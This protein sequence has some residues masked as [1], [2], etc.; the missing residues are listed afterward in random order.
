MALKIAVIGAGGVGG[1]FGGRLAAAG[2]DVG[3]VARGTHLAALKQDGLTVTSV[4]GDFTIA[5]VQAT[6]DPG[7][8]GEVDFVLLAVKTWQLEAAITA[9][10]PLIGPET[11]VVTTQNGVDAPGQVAEVVGRNAVLPGAV[12][13]IA[14]L[15]G[16]GRV[17]QLGGGKLTFAEWDNAPSDR[18]ARLR[19]ALQEAGLTAVVATDVWAALWEKFLALA[20][21]GAIGTV[22]DA[23]YGVLRARAG[24]RRLIA[25]SMA[26]IAQVARAKGIRLADDVVAAEIAFLDQL[27]PDG[28]TSLQRDI[29]AGRPSELEAWAGTVVRLGRET[30]TPTPVNDLLHELASTRA[31]AVKAG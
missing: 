6:D 14:F 15:D 28:T 19:A 7:E 25:D 13:V 31:Q 24:T 11:A 22:T 2:H 23:P 17:R 18:V 21:L 3:F 20:S 12:E 26:E 29:R 5:P 9:A 8:I 1:Y 16:P 10:K 4:A 27:P 30:G